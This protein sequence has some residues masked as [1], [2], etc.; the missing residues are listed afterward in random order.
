[1][2]NLMELKRTYK[3]S[4]QKLKEMAIKIL[5]NSGYGCFGNL[6]FEYIDP[7]V[8]ELI[9][10][11]GQYTI[12]ELEKYAGNKMIY[13]DTDSIYLTSQDNEII[14]KAADL[15]VIL[16]F[17][18]SWKGLFV[19]PNKKQYF[20]I[21]ADGREVRKTLK[22]I[23]NDQ[24]AYF[25]DVTTKLIS[26]GFMEL[27]INADVAIDIDPLDKIVSYIRS[28]F[29]QLT[30]INIDQLAFS[31]EAKKNLYDYKNN[32]GERQIYNEIVED[33]SGNIE[34]AKTKAQAKEVY[35][36]WK[37]A[38]EKGKGK[39]AT[40]HPEKYQLNTTQYKIELFNCIEPIL[41]AYGMKEEEIK[42]LETEV[43]AP[44]MS[45]KR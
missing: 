20:G 29:S 37:I 26:K 36:Y 16:E 11:F 39:S 40:M 27:V 13:G 44:E 24:P 12:K 23:K 19:T 15:D 38:G 28:A 10:A 42:T 5:M 22:G 17:E 31:Q 33:C 41:Q 9:T 4:S 18:R 2:S 3:K 6:Y 34:L 8:A 43:G 32:G 45:K 30:E 35:R 7:R 25:N 21:T 14:A 1:M